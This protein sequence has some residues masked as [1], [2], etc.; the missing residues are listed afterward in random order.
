[1]VVGVCVI[2]IFDFIIKK[3][4]HEF[5][6]VAGKK[7]DILL[8]SKLFA[9]TLSMKM[10]ARPK[11]I[12]AFASNLKDF[13]SIRSFITS[14]S[15]IAM[16]DL[17]FIMLFL[18]VIYYVGGALVIIPLITMPIIIIY[19]LIAQFA[20]QRSIEKTYQLSARK[21]ALVIES[22]SNIETVKCLG[23]QSHLQHE[24][25][26][27]VGH[28]AYWSQKSR[29]ISASTN[30]F[31]QLMQQLNMV[32]IVVLGTYLIADLELTMGALIACV[33]LSGRIAGPISQF[34][35]LLANYQQTK[36]A[37]TSLNDIMAQPDES[38]STKDSHISLTNITGDIHLNNVSFGYPEKTTQ[39]LSNVN[40]KIK[41]GERIG[42][43]GRV[44]SGKTS[45][46]RL[47]LGLYEP[48]QGHVLLDGIDIRQCN[49]ADVRRQISY[50]DQSSDLFLGTLKQNVSY[51]LNF[52]D[53][54]HIISALNTAGLSDMVNSDP[55]G[56]DQMIAEKGAN[57][58]GGQR[59]AVAIARA[60]LRNT[61]VLVLDEPTSAMDNLSEESVKANL[62]LHINEKTVIL[63]THKMSMLSLV[64]RVI[65]MDA[66][67]V[68][69]D[70]SKESIISAL[71]QGEIK[72]SL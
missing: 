11:S 57:L 23:A 30:H 10:K 19:G 40:I 59:Q 58:S 45:L 9:K 21:N 2:F 48:N 64:D 13:D 39:A 14:T 54:Q 32:F 24:W 62:K 29:M 67:K 34:A 68:V 46:A 3:L 16:A 41:A 53:D 60:V 66:G 4:R 28:T 71:K 63:I 61:S 52:V 36:T 7:S 65:I 12:G 25:E 35:S 69:A 50:V 51:G 55:Q 38:I 49:L 22:L 43:I 37:F 42:I 8:S 18:F 31:A 27:A 47:L 15:M 1:M 20:V 56:L 17:P 33:M 26:Q 44:G 72:V 5:L 70:G 6:E